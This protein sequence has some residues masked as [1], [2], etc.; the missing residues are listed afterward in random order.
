MGFCRVSSDNMEG[1]L[2]LHIAGGQ[3]E[4]GN[5]CQRV[6]QQ[7]VLAVGTSGDD[8]DGI[9]AY[10]FLIL[11]GSED[12]DMV[13]GGMIQRTIDGCTASHERR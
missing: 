6:L 4:S 11:I 13:I 10:A 9:G 5:A 1:V 12:G 3:I 2:G 8:P 7:R